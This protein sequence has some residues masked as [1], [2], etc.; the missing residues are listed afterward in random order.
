MF[1]HYNNIIKLV[2]YILTGYQVLSIVC[3]NQ[4]RGAR[5]THNILPQYIGAFLGS[6]THVCNL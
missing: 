6:L 3:L 4:L 1:P 5:H 2:L